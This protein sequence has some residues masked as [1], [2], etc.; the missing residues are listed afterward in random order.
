MAG[1]KKEKGGEEKLENDDRQLSKLSTSVR[2]K[3]KTRF[4]ANRAIFWSLSDY[5]EPICPE[6]RL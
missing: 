5:K 4:E 2:I 6:T 1:A 3:I